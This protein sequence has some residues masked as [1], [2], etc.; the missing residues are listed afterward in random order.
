MYS[1]VTREAPRALSSSARTSLVSSGQVAIKVIDGTDMISCI[2]DGLMM[3]ACP[4]HNRTSELKRKI[5]K[6]V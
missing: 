5:A 2:K 1:M 6:L 3:L 4:Y